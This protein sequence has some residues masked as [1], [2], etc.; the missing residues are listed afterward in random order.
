MYHFGTRDAGTRE[1]RPMSE[2]FLKILRVCDAKAERD[3][4]Q[5]SRILVI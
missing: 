3:P 2:V 4:D 5:T 1:R